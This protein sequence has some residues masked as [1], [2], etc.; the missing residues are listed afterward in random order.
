MHH[1]DGGS[2]IDEIGL[3][4]WK[5]VH[6]FLHTIDFREFLVELIDEDYCKAVLLFEV[7]EYRHARFHGIASIDLDI[8]L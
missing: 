7:S 2:S 5:I 4:P 3:H 6:S 8:T 1:F